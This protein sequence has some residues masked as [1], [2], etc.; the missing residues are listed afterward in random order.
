MNCVLTKADTRNTNSHV[1]PMK[2]NISDEIIP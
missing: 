2:C 1:P